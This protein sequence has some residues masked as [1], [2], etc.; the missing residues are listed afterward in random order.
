MTTSDKPKSFTHELI[1]NYLKSC[2]F[3]QVRFESNMFDYRA[4]ECLDNSFN[5]R[6]FEK[7]GWGRATV[8]N[9]LANNRV[10]DS[11]AA[12]VV[13]IVWFSRTQDGAGILYNATSWSGLVDRLARVRL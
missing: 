9:N 1:C 7:Q 12:D 2:G 4:L 5:I 11:D 3:A 6:V 8:A 10:L 13:K